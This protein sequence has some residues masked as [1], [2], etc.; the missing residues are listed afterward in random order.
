MPSE[1]ELEPDDR[2]GA[3]RRPYTRRVEMIELCNTRT[4]GSALGHDLSATGVRVV[5]YPEMEP[6]SQVTLALYGGPREEPVV[7]CAEVIRAAGPD[8]VAFHFEELSDSQRAGL[9]KL[10]IGLAPLESLKNDPE[11]ERVVVTRILER[12]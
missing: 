2:R 11:G 3:A 1:P 5:G 4:H 8:Q 7:V 10:T 12:E 6:G 9:E